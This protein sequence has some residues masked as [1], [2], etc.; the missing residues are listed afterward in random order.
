ME[1]EENENTEEIVNTDVLKCELNTLSRADG[2]SIL[3]QSMS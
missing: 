3:C 1:I 2:S